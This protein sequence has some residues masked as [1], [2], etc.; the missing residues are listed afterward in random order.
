MSNSER[1][2]PRPEQPPPSGG[3]RRKQPPG[4]PEAGRCTED[5]NLFRK[6]QR[7]ATASPSRPRSPAAATAPARNNNLRLSSE[8]DQLIYVGW[9]TTSATQTWYLGF[10][11]RWNRLAWLKKPEKIKNIASRVIE[12]GGDGFD[13][14]N[15]PVVLKVP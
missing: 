8:V 11:R 15:R 1:A 13:L 9:R 3:Q 10:S 6:S 5:R 4:R 12:C 7:G 14:W 2:D